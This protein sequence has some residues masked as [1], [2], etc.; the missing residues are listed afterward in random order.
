ME[1][2]WCYW[3]WPEQISK[4]YDEAREKLYGDTIPLKF[5]PS[6]IVWEDENFDSAEWCLENFST[7]AGNNTNAELEVIRWSL[8][9][10]V[11]VPMRIRTLN[12][13]Y[14][15]ACDRGGDV[16][17]EQFPPPEDVVMV[18]LKDENDE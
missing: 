17:P 7:H 8:E 9:E 18:K 3:G 2:W 15:A 1:C 5:G 4:I 12:A 11:K 13:A 6:H 10:L 16:A 14:E